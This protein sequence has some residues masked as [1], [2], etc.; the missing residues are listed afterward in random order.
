VGALSLETLANLGEFVSGVAVVV[1]LVYLALQ[2]RQNTRSLRTEN[3]ARALERL[4]S[5][6][7]RLGEDSDLARVFAR[8][9]LDTRAL[10]PDQ[11]VQFTWAFYEMFGAFEFMFHQA[12]AGALPAEVWQRWSATL[13]WW[14]SLPGVQTWWHAKPAPFSASFSSFVDACL[15]DNPVDVEAAGRWQEFLA[16]PGG[17]RSGSGAGP[18]SDGAGR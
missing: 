1:S 8:G 5:L 6:Q 13:A 3:Y 17:P 15:H 7:S 14:L 2:V 9:L 18:G 16:G 11:R 10:S 4:A 12:Q